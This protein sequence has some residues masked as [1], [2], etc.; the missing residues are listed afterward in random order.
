[1]RASALLAATAIAAVYVLSPLTVWFTLAM[2]PIV[3]LSSRGLDPD[4]R[5]WR[6]ANSS[7]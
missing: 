1:M 7:C 4:E 5:R 6:D 3:V 2:V